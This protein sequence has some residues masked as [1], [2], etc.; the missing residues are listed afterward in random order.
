MA[1]IKNSDILKDYDLGKTLGSGSFATVKV[2]TN[3]TTKEKFAI[4]IIEKENCQD[5]SILNEIEILQRISHP[6]VVALYEAYQ[7]PKRLYLVMELVTGGELYDRIV[8]RGNYTEKDAATL[9]ATIVK[10]IAYLHDNGVVH[11]DLKPEN[12]LYASEASDAEIKI[13]DFGLSKVLNHDKSMTTL[14]GSP[15]YVAPEILSNKGYDK[16]VDMWSIGVLLYI[17]LCG[18]PPFYS[19]SEPVLFKQIMKGQFDF[20]DPEWTDISPAAKELVTKL[21]DV[22]PKTRLTAAQALKHPWI[23]TEDGASGR[24]LQDTIKALKI[25]NAKHKFKVAAKG[26]IAAG[27]LAALRVGGKSPAEGSS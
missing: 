14:C 25:F 8:A 20:P 11:R 24:S 22:N 19:E 7:T 27:K 4:K 10:A 23:A 2:G 15:L 12:L 21:L 16:A 5:D 26:I 6:N 17:L 18:F 3:K 9:I 1:K 13:T